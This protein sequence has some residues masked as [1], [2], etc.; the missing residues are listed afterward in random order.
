MPKDLATPGQLLF[1]DTLPGE[2]SD[3]ILA[4]IRTGGVYVRPMIVGGAFVG[5]TCES[6]A[7]GGT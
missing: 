7:G 3:P 2:E 4:R 1:P 5:E 6:G